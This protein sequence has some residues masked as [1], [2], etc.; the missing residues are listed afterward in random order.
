MP[1]SQPGIR[2]QTQ[3]DDLIDFSGTITTGGA[4]QLVLVQ[5]LRRLSLSIW[6][7]SAANMTVGIGPPRPTANL[8]GS[9]V[10]SVTVGNAGIGYTV[11]PVV[12]FLG[13]IVDGDYQT[14]PSHPA[15]AHATLSGTGIGSITI[16][17]PGTGYAV[18]PLVYLE[19]PIIG[20]F[21]KLGGGCFLPSITAGI[22]LPPGWQLNFE[23]S[24]LVPAS[25]LAVWGTNTSDAFAVKVGGLV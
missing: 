21:G 17:D 1:V 8:T 23:G 12:R 19:N 11:P 16:D 5:Q 9:T 15:A 24:I 20:P 14:A 6:N 10:S 18:A 13:G 22:P 7:T 2:N 25:A 4:A 3:L